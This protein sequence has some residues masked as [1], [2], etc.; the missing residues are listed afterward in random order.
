MTELTIMF[1]AGLLLGGIL[2]GIAGNRLIVNSLR[3]RIVWSEKLL[4]R[5]RYE[6]RL[7]LDTI[8]RYSK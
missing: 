2:T 1:G 5:L 3:E 6:N 7:L 4:A 8:E